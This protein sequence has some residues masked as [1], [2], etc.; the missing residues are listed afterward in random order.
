[1]NN[2]LALRVA[3]AL[4]AATERGW[5]WLRGAFALLVAGTVAGVFLGPRAFGVGAV[6]GMICAFH[7]AALFLEGM[8]KAADAIGAAYGVAPSGGS[9]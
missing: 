8:A 2:P 1:M 4:A 7:A 6:L 3:D 9:S 5:R